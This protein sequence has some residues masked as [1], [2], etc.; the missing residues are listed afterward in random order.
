MSTM[1]DI[2]TSDLLYIWDSYMRIFHTIC[3]YG[4]C[5]PEPNI[6]STGGDCINCVDCWLT[7]VE[8][9][10]KERNKNEKDGVVDEL[11]ESGKEDT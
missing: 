7:A 9:E 6:K 11:K 8:N 10:L 2:D 3:L 1:K 5:P 4:N